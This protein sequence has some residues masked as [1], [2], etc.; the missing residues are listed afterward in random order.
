ML[1]PDP[2]AG[3]PPSACKAKGPGD[4]RGLLNCPLSLGQFPKVKLLPAPCQS[5]WIASFSAPTSAQKP[6]D[7]FLIPP[8]PFVAQVPGPLPHGAFARQSIQRNP[9][10]ESRIMV[11]VS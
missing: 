8:V 11:P 3:A 2:R 10:R 9:R 6:A 7:A 5:R 4:C 1:R